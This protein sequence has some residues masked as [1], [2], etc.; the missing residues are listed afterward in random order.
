MSNGKK[1]ECNGPLATKGYPRYPEGD[2]TWSCV[3][4]DAAILWLTD[5]NTFLAVH[6][7]P[8][9]GYRPSEDEDGKPSEPLVG[10]LARHWTPREMLLVEP[11]E[12][13]NEQDWQNSKWKCTAHEN[14]LPLKWGFGDRRYF[15]VCS[16]CLIEWIC[17]SG[18]AATGGEVPQHDVPSDVLSWQCIV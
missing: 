14:A 6:H 12:I 8:F 4:D 15:A 16:E 11:Q 2:V 18:L 13:Q 9:C 3:E 7:C 17:G 5:G 10:P 1:H